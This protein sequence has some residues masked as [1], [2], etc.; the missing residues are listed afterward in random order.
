MSIWGRFG[1]CR[2]DTTKELEAPP[3]RGGS[4]SS[5][6]K[7]TTSVAS[8]C[9]D[10]AT[11]LDSYLSSLR[12]PVSPLPQTEILDLDLLP[13][14]PKGKKLGA[15]GFGSVHE[16]PKNPNFAVKSFERDEFSSRDSGEVLGFLEKPHPNV[17]GALAMRVEYPILKLFKRTKTAIQAAEI[18]EKTQVKVIAV[19]LPKA[20]SNLYGYIQ[21]GQHPLSFS[22]ATGLLAQ[23]F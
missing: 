5:S 11:T 22:K 7:K 17:C 14:S 3:R 9:I 8:G 15:G 1:L 19:L 13:P 2:P 12:S 21:K 10:S 4:P 20:E 16:N 6:D 23:I 18:P